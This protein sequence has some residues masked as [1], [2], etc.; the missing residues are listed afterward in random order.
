MAMLQQINV[1][2]YFDWQV[3]ELMCTYIH[4]Y[5]YVYM[6]IYIHIHI[7]KHTQTH[8]WLWH[9]CSKSTYV[10]ISTGRYLN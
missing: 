10:C 4:V 7:H 5:I 8:Y 9:C 3:L 2:V 1:P 6:H